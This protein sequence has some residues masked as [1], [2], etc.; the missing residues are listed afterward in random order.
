VAF[1]TA[2]V[3]ATTHIGISVLIVLAALPMETMA[4]GEAGSAPLLEDFSLFLLGLS[5]LWLIWQGIRT[6]AHR[7]DGPWFGLAAGLIPCPLTLF[8]MTFAAD[9]GV[10]L[11]G[12]GFAV[13][14]LIGVTLV[15]GAVALSGAVLGT[16]LSRILPGTARAA[17]GLS[18]AA[19]LALVWISIAALLR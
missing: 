13:M 8:V 19:G 11:A 5:G 16:G 14:T 17:R 12:L 18:V 2:M 15:L 9:K 3:L 4:R 10:T 1:R 6:A 7:H